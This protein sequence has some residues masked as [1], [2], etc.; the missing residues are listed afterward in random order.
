MERAVFTQSAAIAGAVITMNPIA[1]KDKGLIMT[2]VWESRVVD[3]KLVQDVSS[4]L[5][6]WLGSLGRDGRLTFEGSK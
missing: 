5:E 1:V 4:D 2:C 3:D 6:T